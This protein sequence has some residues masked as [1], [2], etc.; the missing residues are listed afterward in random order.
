MF[1][2]VRAVVLGREV[3]AVLGQH[4]PKGMQLDEVVADLES[5]RVSLTSTTCTSEP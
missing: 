2:A 5:V 3:L 1:V 4:V